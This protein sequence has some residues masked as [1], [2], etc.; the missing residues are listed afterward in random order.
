MAVTDEDLQKLG[1][2][3][4]YSGKEDEWN[5]WSFVMK[6]YVSFLSTHV[7]ALLTGA[8]NPAASPD[9]SIATIRATLTEDG[10]TAAKKLFHVLVMN[11][12]GP[13][14]AVIRGITDMNGALAWRALI[15][16][17]A[18]NTAP[19][20]Q[21]LMSAILNAKTFPSELTAYEIALDEWQENIRKW[22]S[23]SGDRFN[24]SM[25]K[26]LFLDKAPMNVRV[27]LQM[28]NLATFEAMTAV[29]LQ[30]LQHN[31][32]YQAGVTVT[33]NNRRGPDDME[34]DALTK[35]GKGKSK[36]K[37]KTDGSK[38]SCFVCGRVGHMA[39]DCWFKDTSK[40]CTPNNKGKKG[41]GKG[42]GKNSVNEVTTPIESTPT[43]PDNLLQNEHA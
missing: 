5:E 26:A 25:K 20:V 42:K 2:P 29:T 22:E 14:L 39:K 15:T 12:R 31:A 40:G 1:K 6:S 33:P 34:I 13:A 43:P 30:F 38:T 21:S 28:Q 9:M 10:V 27:P 23:I 3:P 16:R 4:I 37:S 19:R 11:V 41:K 32:Q 35:K 18:P 8:E 36:G 7:P 24:V 17:Y